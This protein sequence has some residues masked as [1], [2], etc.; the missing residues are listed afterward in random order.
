MGMFVNKK[1]RLPFVNQFIKY[2][3]SGMSTVIAVPV[4]KAPAWA[5]R[6]S[7]LLLW[8]QVSSHDGASVFA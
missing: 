5:T 6:I 1:R 3:K 7:K 2:F 4:P 8:G